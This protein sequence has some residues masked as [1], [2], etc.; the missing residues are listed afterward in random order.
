MLTTSSLSSLNVSSQCQTL[1]AIEQRFFVF[2]CFFSNA[3]LVLDFTI[4]YQDWHRRTSKS[5]DTFWH[6]N[7]RHLN[8]ITNWF[9]TFERKKE[10]KT[11]EPA[12]S[13]SCRREGSDTL[14]QNALLYL[15]APIHSHQSLSCFWFAVVV[16]VVARFVFWSG[17]IMLPPFR[18]VTHSAIWGRVSLRCFS[19]QM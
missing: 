19:L 3:G 2:C 10:K 14:K 7:Q 4:H 15:N 18:C 13:L 16:V 17:V 5:V 9:R 6:A 8:S 11:K 1:H 12:G